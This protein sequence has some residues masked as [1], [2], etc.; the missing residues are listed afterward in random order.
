MLSPHEFA[1]LMLIEDSPDEIDLGHPGLGTLMERR[2]VELE[3]L[4]SG[5]QRPC[6]TADGY[7]FLRAA[8]RIR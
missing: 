5:R 8:A 6:I 2:L 1:T 7:S 4:A 3:Q